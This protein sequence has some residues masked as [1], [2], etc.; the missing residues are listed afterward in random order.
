MVSIFLQKGTIIPTVETE[1]HYISQPSP[2]LR[3]LCL[4]SLWLMKILK[5]N[6]NAN[7]KVLS[8]VPVVWYQCNSLWP[9]SLLSV[10]EPENGCAV[11]ELFHSSR[12]PQRRP[13]EA[14]RNPARGT[15]VLAG[16]SMKLITP[17]PWLSWGWSP[18][19]S[20]WVRLL[21][22]QPATLPLDGLFVCF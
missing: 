19:L 1:Y 12:T 7:N 14:G 21:G 8:C 15:W 4:S 16:N 13:G 20:L 10:S 6:H 17:E 5:R 2:E 11:G 3:S 9:P 18:C 22:S